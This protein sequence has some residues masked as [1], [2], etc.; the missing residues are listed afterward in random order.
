LDFIPSENEDQ[1]LQLTIS[2]GE[3]KQLDEKFIPD[4]IA[5]VDHYDKYDKDSF[6][7]NNTAKAISAKSAAFGF[8]TQAG[9]LAYTVTALDPLAKTFTLDSV[10]GLEVDD[11]YTVDISFYKADGTA[12]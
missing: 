7:A 3:L 9:S 6:S 4:T 8:N 1:C 10:E 12:T 2:C 5:R 11:I